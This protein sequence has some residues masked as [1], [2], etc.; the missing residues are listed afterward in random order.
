MEFHKYQNRDEYIKA[1]AN[2]FSKRWLVWVLDG[3][4]YLVSDYIQ[5]N[6]SNPTFGICHGVRGGY[7]VERFRQTLGCDVIGTDLFQDQEQSDHV[8]Q[9]DFHEVNREWLDSVDFIY[10]NALDH[11]YD[12]EM[13]VAQWARCLKRMGLCFLHWGPGHEEN[14]VGTGDCFAASACEYQRLIE[15]CLSLQDKIEVGRSVIF[16]GRKER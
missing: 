12:S 1:Q 15:G 4:L 10:S 2:S 16:V 6:M 11:S 9:M 3:E 5:R 7:E 13:C 14:T 8:I